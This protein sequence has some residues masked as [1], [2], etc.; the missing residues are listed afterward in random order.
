[1]F[2]FADIVV[3][4]IVV[5]GL[6][7]TGLYFLNKWAAKKMSTNESLI[8]RSKQTMSIF[9][10]DKKFVKAKDSSLP[11]AVI[12]QLPKFYRFRKAPL[13]KAKIGAQLVTLMCDKNVYAALP[14]KK[15][16]KVEIAGIYILSMQGMKTAKEIKAIKK[17]KNK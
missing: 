15:N 10:I 5:V 2:T 8:A 7:G 6:L 3:I 9:V 16:V 12:D 17:N 13:V 1:M 14:L 4:I 11:K